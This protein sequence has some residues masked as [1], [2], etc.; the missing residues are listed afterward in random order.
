M[1]TAPSDR[2]LLTIA[3]PTFNRAQYLELCLRQ[4]IPDKA[5]FSNETVELLVA[6]NC[7]CD[8][9]GSVVDTFRQQGLE[10]RSI[11][12]ET[13]IGSDA[14][15]AMCFN[16]ARGRYVQILGDD[17]LYLPGKLQE[18]VELLDKNEY[19]VVCLKSYGYE[20]DFVKECPAGPNG[21][22]YFSNVL[23]FISEVGPLIT[24]VSACIINK[25]LQKETDASKFCGSNLVQVHLVILSLVRAR[26]NAY[27]QGYTLACK[28]ANSDG[29]DFSEVF[30]EKLFSILRSYEAQ[31]FPRSAT[32][33]LGNKML[34]SYY[35]FNLLR[36]RL[37]RKGDSDVTFRRFKAQFGGRK[38]FYFFC[39]PIIL[40]PRSLAVLWGLGAALIGRAYNGEL[41]RGWYFAMHRLST[42]RRRY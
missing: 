37:L 18:V 17:D 2:P 33:I 31:G 24:F 29:Y 11:R 21:Q 35:P 6:D 28:R 27:V 34:V 3:I 26:I 15:I 20:R 8:H 25:D 13:N 39:A 40:L 16:M 19:G 36:Q 38:T 14:N 41:R 1:K 32:D 23:N 4:F 9:T 5:L 10:I 12:N 30:V 42:M 22:R 7:S